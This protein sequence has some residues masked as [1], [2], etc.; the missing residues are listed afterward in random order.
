MTDDNDIDDQEHKVEADTSLYLAEAIFPSEILPAYA[1]ISTKAEAKHYAAVEATTLLGEAVIDII[2]DLK[3]LQE[4]HKETK[5]KY[6]KST[7]DSTKK[8]N[9]DNYVKEANKLKMTVDKTILA[10]YR[11]HTRQ[12]LTH[13]VSV[14]GR[15]RQEATGIQTSHRTGTSPP[16]HKRSRWE[17]LTGGNKEPTIGEK[18]NDK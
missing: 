12:Q 11:I 4:K 16:I 5:L 15:G 13:G 6:D 14:K 8:K 7:K 17:K 3:D 2:K 18:V 9:W 10:H 1:G